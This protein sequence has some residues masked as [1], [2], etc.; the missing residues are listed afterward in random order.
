[1]STHFRSFRLKRIQKECENSYNRGITE[2][3]A[4]EKGGQLQSY[5]PKRLALYLNLSVFYYE[6]STAIEKAI[7]T[8]E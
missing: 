3:K 1:M 6:I 4:E 8:C 7:E 2:M 5:D